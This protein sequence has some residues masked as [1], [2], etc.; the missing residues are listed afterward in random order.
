MCDIDVFG[1]HFNSAEHAYQ[2]K[3]AIDANEPHLAVQ[4]KRAVHA[5]K[6]K[7]LSKAIPDEF[8]KQW[9]ENSVEVMQEIITAKIHQV[10]E[11]KD[12]LLKTGKAY[13]AEAT[14]DKFWASGLSVENTAKVNPDYFPGSNKLGQLL[15][16]L[17]EF[18]L[19]NS[20]AESSQ[21][22]VDAQATDKEDYIE[23]SPFMPE[24]NN[25]TAN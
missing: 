17:R 15:M 11:F 8:C 10:P 7:G 19:D 24:K 1:E 2:W 13:L 16:D 6:A 23:S 14:F 4:I 22:D 18:L 3:K 5:G 9:E 20:D 21:E 25:S 12:Y